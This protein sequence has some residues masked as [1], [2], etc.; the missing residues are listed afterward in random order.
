M[1]KNKLINNSAIAVL[2]LSIGFYSFLYKSD[3]PKKLVTNQAIN[4]AQVETDPISNNVLR[5]ASAESFESNSTTVELNN[6]MIYTN[7]QIKN[8]EIALF[9]EAILST[10]FYSIYPNSPFRLYNENINKAMA[11]NDVAQYKV[12]LALRECMGVASKGAIDKLEVENGYNDIIPRLKAHNSY[13]QELI[14]AVSIEKLHVY[15]T[16]YNWLVKS[17]ENGNVLARALM[18]ARE[19]EL[20]KADEALDIV[21][22][23]LTTREQEDFNAFSALQ[24]YITYYDYNAGLH[25]AIEV[26]LCKIN[27]WCDADVII[28]YLEYVEKYVDAVDI[29]QQSNDI[30]ELIKSHDIPG[31]ITY[32]GIEN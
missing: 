6:S 18:F 21:I 31:L 15:T 32:L 20:Y 7:Q 8:F 27:A 24:R 14:E 16:H 22:S 19:P 10:G 23:A 11:G 2:L 1:S 30:T 3:Q 5:L 4:D 25:S 26:A 12:A 29:K 13:C 28:A 9:P 17:H